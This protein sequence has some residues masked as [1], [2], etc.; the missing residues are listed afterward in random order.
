[1]PVSSSYFGVSGYRVL[2]NCGGVF[3]SSGFRQMSLAIDFLFSRGRFLTLL[4]RKKHGN[5]FFIANSFVS[6][7]M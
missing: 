7:L 2:A 4:S 1:M 6:L 5:I 3:L